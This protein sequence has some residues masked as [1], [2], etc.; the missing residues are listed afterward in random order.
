[1]AL[2]HHVSFNSVETQIHLISLVHPVYS[3]TWVCFI[4]P[5]LPPQPLRVVYWARTL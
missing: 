1:M 5:P 3:V 2:Y 4:L